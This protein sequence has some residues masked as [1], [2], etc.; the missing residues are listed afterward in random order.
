MSEAFLLFGNVHVTVHRNPFTLLTTHLSRPWLLAVIQLALAL[1][2][3]AIILFKVFGST[4]KLVVHDHYRFAVWFLG[5]IVFNVVLQGIVFPFATDNCTP[6]MASG[7]TAV[8]G[9]I[10]YAGH[11]LVYS[12]SLDRLVGRRWMAEAVAYAAD[13]PR[14]FVF[15]ANQLIVWPQLKPYGR[16]RPLVAAVISIP[17]F[18]MYAVDNKML[19][20]A[21]Q[22]THTCVMDLK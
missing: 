2:G 12:Y 18:L 20:L 4:R 14:P 19:P 13:V 7:I 3:L 5:N 22:V 17:G 11:W 15:I 1:P 21:S 8:S 16:F 9:L 6:E 10:S